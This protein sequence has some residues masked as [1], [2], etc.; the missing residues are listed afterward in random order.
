MSFETPEQFVARLRAQEPPEMRR[1]RWLLAMSYAGS[2]L[3]RD[4]GEYSDAESG[5]DFRRDSV[6]EIERKMLAYGE[7]QRAIRHEAHNAGL[8]GGPDAPAA[9]PSRL[10]P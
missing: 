10:K 6:A 3:Y 9:G 7:R 4:D 1:L 5:I 8:S 2:R